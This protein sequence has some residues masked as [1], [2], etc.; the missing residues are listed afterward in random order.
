MS[1]WNTLFL[2][3]GFVLT[4]NAHLDQIWEINR[5]R[6]HLKLCALQTAVKPQ[7]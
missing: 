4:G 1:L 3:L 5:Q 2:L 6:V 7:L